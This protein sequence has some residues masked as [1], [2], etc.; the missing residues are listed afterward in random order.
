M[1]LSFLR[2]FL[3]FAKAAAAATPNRV[4]DAAIQLIEE[5]LTKLPTDEDGALAKINGLRASL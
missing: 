5:I 4:D 3:P 1:F 2:M